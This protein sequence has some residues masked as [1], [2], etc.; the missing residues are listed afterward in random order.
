MEGGGRCHADQS[1]PV[2]PRTPAPSWL[3][4]CG[5]DL[6]SSRPSSTSRLSPDRS[7][8]CCVRHLPARPWARS[9]GARLGGSGRALQCSPSTERALRGAEILGPLSL[10]PGRLAPPRPRAPR[11]HT[12]RPAGEKRSGEGSGPLRAGRRRL[13]PR[14]PP[15]QPQP[16][17]TGRAGTHSALRKRGARLMP[18]PGRPLFSPRRC[19]L[20]R[21]WRGSLPGMDTT[22]ASGSPQVPGD[23]EL[24]KTNCNLLSPPT[25][26][27]R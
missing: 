4:L 3:S 15:P 24:G 26:S 8:S 7:P 18:A 23:G 19:I 21:R 10:S 14:P 27:A 25:P 17:P 20:G 16:R 22:P 5:G 13:R 2:Q 12:P 1:S 11:A 9:W 6:R